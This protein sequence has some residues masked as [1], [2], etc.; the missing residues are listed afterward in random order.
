MVFDEIKKEQRKKN[1]FV[2]FECIGDV[3]V[4]YFSCEFVQNKI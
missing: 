1:Q 4:A 2:L 3:E